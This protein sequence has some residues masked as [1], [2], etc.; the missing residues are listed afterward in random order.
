MITCSKRYGYQTSDN[1]KSSRVNNSN[2]KEGEVPA[3]NEKVKDN[4]DSE[5]TMFY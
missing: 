1:N 2:L 3:D 4:N 5:S